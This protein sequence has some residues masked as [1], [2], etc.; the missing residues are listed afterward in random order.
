MQE[1]P[2]EYKITT[3][4]FQNY[5]ENMCPKAKNKIDSHSLIT[6]IKKYPFYSKLRL[7]TEYNNDHPNANISMHQLRMFLKLYGIRKKTVKAKN[8][9]TLTQ[10]FINGKFFFLK[11]LLQ[12]FANENTIYFTDE[13]SI[14]PY[15][16]RKGWIYKNNYFKNYS[17]IY[18]SNLRPIKII[19]TCSLNGVIYYSTSN[20]NTNTKL[21]KE[22]LLNAIDKINETDDNYW[23]FLDNVNFHHS[24]SVKELLKEEEIPL[25]YGV[26]YFPDFD[27]AEMIFNKLKAD[28]RNEIYSTQ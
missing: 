17:I 10:Q 9:Y 18:K 26:K 20:K 3:D 23:F 27:F 8:K 6:K 11:L 2:N 13:C 25:L 1:E 4:D 21:F 5:L 12:C 7:L 14:N 28:L 16:N 24:K 22:Y 19:L 15:D